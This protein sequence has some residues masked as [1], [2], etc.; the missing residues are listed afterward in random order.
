MPTLYELKQSLGMIGQQLKQKN[1][2]LGKKAT[3]PNVSMDDINQL[4]TEKEDLERRFQIVE[5]QVKEIEQKEKSKVKD[6]TE[7]YTGLDDS[8][9]LVKAKAEF[10][11]HAI[12]PNEFAKP[13]QEAQR[14]LHALP[15]GN[16]SGGDKFLPKTLSKEIVSEPFA[17]NQLREKARL[18][19]IKGLEIPRVSYTLDDDDFITDLETAKELELKGDTVKYGTNKF[20]VFAAISDTVIH[21]SD[22]DLVNWVE[23]ALAS[24]LAAKER[25]DALA[26]APK[27][28]LE[29]MSFYNGKIKEVEG[30]G[31]YNAVV[32]ALADLHED[33]R[34]N[35]VIYMRYSDYVSIIATLSNG[36]TNFFDTPAEKVFGKPVVFTDAA[37]KPIVG[38]FNYFGI[39][40]DN[41]TYDTD[42]DVK[43]GEYLFVLTAWYDQQRTLDS[44]FRI[45]KVVEMP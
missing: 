39:N 3:D 9:K 37:V 14:L 44:A 36:T 27:S 6:N 17:K 38:D 42:K 45:A 28:G 16:E 31:I 1:E 32:N 8:E 25:K 5:S 34:E 29:H 12:L 21:G 13:S 19:N 7:G 18:T 20:K 24:G 15:T 22:V 2:D 30:A 26:V 43:K 4:K 41:T 40:Y 23:N 10:Y 35:A 11:R 33:Y